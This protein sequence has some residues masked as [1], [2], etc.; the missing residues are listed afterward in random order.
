MNEQHAF[1]GRLR[2]GSRS[3]FTLMEVALAILVMALGVVAVFSLIASGLDANAMA[4]ADT[5]AGLFADNVFR[6]I[7]AESISAAVGVHPDPKYS[8]SQQDS[9]A[10]TRWDDF[11]D[12]FEKGGHEITIAAPELWHEPVVVRPGDAVQSPEF[13]IKDLRDGVGDTARIQA[14]ENHTL[15]YRLKVAES[16][17]EPGNFTATLSVWEGKF[18]PTD[19]KRALV[20]YSEFYNPGDL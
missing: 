20:F 9:T 3:G 1:P 4:V 18:G 15:R 16:A 2:A 5:Q 8:R 7:R 13:K 10:E 11:W 19:E 6:G 12:D 17:A 14:I